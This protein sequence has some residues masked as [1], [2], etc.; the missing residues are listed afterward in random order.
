MHGQTAMLLTAAT[1]HPSQSTELPTQWHCARPHV[2]R[3]IKGPIHNTATI[4]HEV[5]LHPSISTLNKA[6]H[7][8]AWKDTF[9]NSQQ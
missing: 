7:A 1:T 3:H 9:V 4:N 8:Q 2:P 6:I 5:M